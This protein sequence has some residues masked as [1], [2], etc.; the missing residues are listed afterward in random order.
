M[1][2]TEAPTR[3]KFDGTI[4]PYYF[5]INLAV[6]GRPDIGL[7]TLWTARGQ[8][9]KKLDSSN[10]GLRGPLYSEAG[11][12]WLVRDVL[13][14]PSIRTVVFSGANAN[15][16]YKG[17]LAV[18]NNGINSDGEV[19]GL[20]GPDGKPA[21]KFAQPGLSQEAVDLFR[22]NVE[23]VNMLGENWEVVQRRIQEIPARSPF[24]SER[25]LF[26]KVAF[27]AERLPGERIGVRVERERIADAWV[28]L[29]AK[30]RREGVIKNSDKGQKIQELASLSVIIHED[31]ETLL[32]KIPGW[33]P[34]SRAKIEQYLPQMLDKTPPEGVN[35]AYTYGAKMQNYEGLDQLQECVNLI[36]SELDTKRAY[37]TTWHLPNN[38]I[39]QVASA[40]CLTDV[41][42]L[43]QDRQLL[44]VAHF[45]SNDMVRAWPLNAY[46]LRALQGKLAKEIG[47]SAGPL[48]IKSNS[49]HIWEETAPQ[50]DDIIKSQYKRVRLLWQ[51][52]PRGNF[53]IAVNDKSRLIEVYHLDRSG[54]MTGKAFKGTEAR[55][56]YK[57]II[58]EQD[59]VSMPNHA[60]YLVDQLHLAEQCLRT[61]VPFIQEEA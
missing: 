15:D 24:M 19:L 21:V 30:I 26:P 42:L 51:E 23:V 48:E 12:E 18:K 35:M 43:V 27:E 37:V 49:A 1:D 6:G 7:A 53:I 44:M 13:A 10:Y 36:K 56:L 33:F 34:I 2:I 40:P 17:L 25:L 39:D 60:A 28:E 31:P 9:D 4:K 50:A 3:E 32:E 45:R 5:E 8:L 29:L 57:E 11:A 55:E 41:N 20:V 16:S 22:N 58:D 59:L 46:G 14:N 38:L 61:G 47:I 54:N 52:D